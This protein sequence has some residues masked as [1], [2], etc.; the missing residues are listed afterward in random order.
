MSAARRATARVL[1]A[2]VRGDG[3]RRPPPALN[4]DLGA[5]HDLSDLCGAAVF[6]GVA[7]YVHHAL[8]AAG[9][10]EIARLVE[11]AYHGVVAGHLR[12]LATLQRVAAVLEPAGIPWLV[13]KGPVLV[14]TAHA[15]DDLRGYGDL[16]VL[17]PPYAFPDALVAL[18]AAGGQAHVH[19]WGFHHRQAAGE[20]PVTLPDGA[21]VDL[22]WDLCNTPELRR[23]FPIDTRSLFERAATVAVGGRDVRTLDP[24]DGLLHLALHT[25]TSG[26]N[27][28]VWLK[29]VEGWLASWDPEDAEIV[30]RA[31]RWRVSLPVA[32]VLTKVGAV[33]EADV[34][35]GLIRRLAPQVGWRAVTRSVWRVSPPAAARPGPSLDRLVMRSV[36]ADQRASAAVLAHKARRLLTP[37]AGRTGGRRTHPADGH[38]RGAYLAAVVSGAFTSGT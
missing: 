23:A 11:P 17:V 9:G 31:H 25:C 15:R 37:S 27:R 30:R 2:S 1:L 22:H 18:E 5:G 12:G 3:W 19:S 13:V 10:P 21:T 33:L 32:V 8:W 29:D 36:R 4:A 20:V 16:D 38:Q 28:L 34:D 24:V 7:G 6:H 14:A 26:G 35:P